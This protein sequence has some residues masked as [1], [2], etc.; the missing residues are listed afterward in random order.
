MAIIKNVI[1][2]GGGPKPGEVA[3]GYDAGGKTLVLPGANG[4]ADY[5]FYN[6]KQLLDW[7]APLDRVVSGVSM[8]QLSGL[9][10]I[11]M[12]FPELINGTLALSSCYSVYGHIVVVA[13]K[14][15]NA[16]SFIRDCR[17]AKSAH[18][19][20]PSATNLGATLWDLHSATDVYIRASS[21][22]DAPRL[23]V[24]CKVM[25]RFAGE[26]PKLKT[27]QNMF[28]ACPKLA[29][30]VPELPSLENA[31]GAF[32]G[33]KLTRESVAGIVQSVPAY[34][35]GNHNIDIGVDSTLL[36]Q[37]DQDALDAIM[38]AKGWTVTWHRN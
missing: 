21:V 27:A 14:L 31:P 26:L 34:D 33:C 17:N 1:S 2:Y 37:E 6:A 16:T 30:F 19:D 29:E 3:I 18:V 28:E 5:L 12:T 32:S 25:V 9:T 4:N 20:I 13:P 15:T 10:S 36:T 24:N 22:T 35:S 8:F 23:C 7:T 11:N 38:V